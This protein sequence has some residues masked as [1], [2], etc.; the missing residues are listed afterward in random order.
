[1][2]SAVHLRYFLA[3]VALFYQTTK[4]NAFASLAEIFFRQ[5]IVCESKNIRN[6][7]AT[8][9]KCVCYDIKFN[10]TLG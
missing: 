3:K 7:V 5:K 6:F 4:E 10:K 9:Q 8:N 1:M 2:P